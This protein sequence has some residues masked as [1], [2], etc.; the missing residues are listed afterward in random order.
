[1]V[2]QDR[3]AGYR[4]VASYLRGKRRVHILAG[5][6]N[7]ELWLLEEKCPAEAEPRYTHANLPVVLEAAREG[8]VLRTLL[9]PPAGM[10]LDQVMEQVEPLPAAAALAIALQV[11]RGLEH[12]HSLKPPVVMGILAPRWVHVG[13]EGTVRLNFLG[14]GGSG[15]DGMPVL[16]PGFAPPEVEPTPR[17][18]VYSLGR[19]LAALLEKAGPE[20]VEAGVQEVVA[21]ATHP[22]PAQRFRDGGELREALARC[23]VQLAL[24]PVRQEVVPSEAGAGDQKQGKEQEQ[25]LPLRPS[26]GGRRTSRRSRSA[27]TAGGS[28]RGRGPTRSG[29]PA[30]SRKR[31]RPRP[32]TR[33]RRKPAWQAWAGAAAQQFWA[34]LQEV[35]AVLRPAFR[36]VGL[37][38]ARLGGADPAGSKA[39]QRSGNRVRA[40]LWERF[41]PLGAMILVVVVLG[42]ILFLQVLHESQPAQTP[43]SLPDAVG[44]G[45]YGPG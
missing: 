25:E 19:I 42:V 39:G 43:P 31:S 4:T 11:A 22:D 41:G 14:V 34:G 5:T 10:T 33:S 37:M 24:A 3:W 15:G 1:M 16:D 26:S 6:D 20:P 2:S 9:E 23:Q 44:P 27:G 18:D 13:A 45:P 40:S 7:R 29:S 21:R 35:P 36:G 12:L 30:R 32:R 8:Q 17:S 38:L 28:A